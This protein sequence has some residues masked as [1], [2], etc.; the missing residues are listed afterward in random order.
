MEQGG[1]R[2]FQRR[3]FFNLA[4]QDAETQADRTNLVLQAMADQGLS[5]VGDAWYS[6]NKD[7]VDANNAQ[8]E[9]TKRQPSFRSVCSLYLQLFRRA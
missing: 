1:A 3:R 6:N 5:D 2:C 7:I 9:F 4:L 8:L